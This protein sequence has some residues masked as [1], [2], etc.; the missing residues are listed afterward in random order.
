[1]CCICKY[2]VNVVEKRLL[3]KDL[4]ISLAY[5][6]IRIGMN[7]KIATV[8]RDYGLELTRPHMV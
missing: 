3:R 4:V 8:G 1:M 7:L 6:N 5:R 2:E